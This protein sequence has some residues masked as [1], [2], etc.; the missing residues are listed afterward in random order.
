MRRILVAGG[1]ALLMLLALPAAVVSAD[2]TYDLNSFAA[3]QNGWTLT[4]SITTDGTIGVLAKS[5]FLAW[6]WTVTEGST[7]YTYASTDSGASLAL[8]NGSTIMTNVT[9][10]QILIPL[11]PAHANGLAL[12]VAGVARLQWINNSD[13]GSYSS[14]LLGISSF[15]LTEKPQMGGY[16]PWIIAGALPVPEPSTLVLAGISL[17]VGLGYTSNWRIRRRRR[18]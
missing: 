3:D 8:Q 16:E 15:W 4:G 11:T 1:A 6:T 13:G 7:S 14:G 9:G 12:T 10:T 18:E 5:D 17:L 2:M